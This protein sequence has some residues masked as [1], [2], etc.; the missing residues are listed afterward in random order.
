MRYTPSKSQS[1]ELSQTNKIRAH[2]AH[3]LRAKRSEMYSVS[4]LTIYL[5]IPLSFRTHGSDGGWIV[6]WAYETN[7]SIACHSGGNAFN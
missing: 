2:K 3:C 5:A 7:L 6:K 1:H 4:K